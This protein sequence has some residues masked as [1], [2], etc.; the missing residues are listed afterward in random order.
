MARTDQALVQSAGTWADAL[1]CWDL[2]RFCQFHS[3][4]PGAGRQLLGCEGR[5]HFSQFCAQ[6]GARPYSG[7]DF[8]EV[9]QNFQ[10]I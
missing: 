5:N 10:R 4:I 3:V 6:P 9:T 8:T 2:T 7:R 1:V